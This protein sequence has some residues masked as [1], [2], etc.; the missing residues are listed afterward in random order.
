MR[1]IFIG[2]L[3]VFL[4]FNFDINASRIGLIPDFLGYIYMMRGLEE[5]TGHSNWFSKLRPLAM[6]MAIYSGILYGMD[7][8][9]VSASLGFLSILLGIGSTIIS[10]YISYGIVMGIKEMENAY[11][12]ELNAESLFS[13]W[14]LLAIFTVLMYI[15]IF[16]PFVNLIGLVVG[17]IINIYF[18]YSFNNTK[19]RYYNYS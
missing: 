2:L 4:D 1:N 18:L 19:N 17:L 10:L 6:G 14:K 5:I 7:L 8:L 13:T 16:I 9:G 12:W 3:L 15:I 11:L